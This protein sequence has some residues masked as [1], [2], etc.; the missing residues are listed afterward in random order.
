MT[1][2]TAP[3]GRL[4]WRAQAACRNVNPDLF[5]PEQAN[6]AANVGVALHICREHCPVWAQCQAWAL[7]EMRERRL[8]PCVAGGVRWVGAQDAQSSRDCGRAQTISR[9][10]TPDRTGC[11]LCGSTAL[12][13]GA[14]RRRA[15]ASR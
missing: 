12:P 11:P 1:D 4:P 15:R 3:T 8:W 6:Q 2:H 9:H 14:R 13:V 10:S 7:H 5:F